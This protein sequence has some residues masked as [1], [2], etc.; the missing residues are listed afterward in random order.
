M[1]SRKLQINFEYQIDAK[2]HQT[3]SKTFYRPDKMRFY[4]NYLVGY[5]LFQ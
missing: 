5:D 2:H 3:R 4:E 1:H